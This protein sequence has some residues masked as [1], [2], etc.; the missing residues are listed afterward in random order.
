[1][2][3]IYVAISLIHKIKQQ[4][5]FNLGKQSVYGDIMRPFWDLKIKQYIS[6]LLFRFLHCQKKC[7]QEL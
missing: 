5:R 2:L 3:E 4:I 1:M 7:L 6:H